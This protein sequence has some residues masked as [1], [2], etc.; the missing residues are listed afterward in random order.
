MCRGKICSTGSAPEQKEHRA[1]VA[2][3]LTQTATNE[4]DLLK[5]VLT[6]DESQLYSYDP[7]TKAQSSQWK[8]PGSPHPKK[9]RQG[10]GKIKTISTVFSD[11]EG[12][13]H[14]YATPGQ[15]INKEYYLN[16]LHR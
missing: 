1:A 8:L 2:N 15:T 14:E 10:C 11:W 12:V 4:A 16:V 7:E 9:V 13:P 5:K 6:G 3:D